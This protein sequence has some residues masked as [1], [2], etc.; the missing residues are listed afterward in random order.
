MDVIAD[1]CCTAESGRLVLEFEDCVNLKGY[2]RFQRSLIVPPSSAQAACVGLATIRCPFGY[3][4]G[5]VDDT[6]R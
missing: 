4:A 6:V 1:V 5:H 3:V 2:N